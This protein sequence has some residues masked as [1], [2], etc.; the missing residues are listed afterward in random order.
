MKK[1]TYIAG[2]LALGF[3][4]FNNVIQTIESIK[5]NLDYM[6]GFAI[7]LIASVLYWILNLKNE[8]RK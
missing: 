8:K 3:V 4:I 5:L 7:S 1:R 6:V 2:I